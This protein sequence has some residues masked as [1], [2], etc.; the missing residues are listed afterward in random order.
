MRTAIEWQWE[1]LLAAR[2]QMDERNHT[3]H[4]A[5]MIPITQTTSQILDT[6][7]DATDQ[8]SIATDMTPQAPS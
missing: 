5:R 6:A 3:K 8:W 7:L 1:Q 2:Q 4:A